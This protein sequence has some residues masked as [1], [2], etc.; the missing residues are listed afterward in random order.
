[1]IIAKL[2]DVEL[3]FPFASRLWTSQTDPT[4]SCSKA[5]VV[6]ISKERIKELIITSTLNYQRK[7]KIEQVGQNVSYFKTIASPTW[8]RPCWDEKGEISTKNRDHW[9]S[10]LTKEIILGLRSMQFMTVMDHQLTLSDY[11]YYVS[12]EFFYLG[13]LY[14]EW[15]TS[16]VIN[17]DMCVL[18]VW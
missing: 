18:F 5:I 3:D 7:I 15:N 6:H 12:S 11:D 4:R 1:M 14:R 8:P 10:W 17:V 13:I 16:V 9:T 2:A